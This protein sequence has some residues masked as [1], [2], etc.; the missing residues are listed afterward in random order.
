M[1]TGDA[2]DLEARDLQFGFQLTPTDD[3]KSRIE[4]VQAGEQAGLDLVGV[5]DHPYK[6]DLLDT[7][8]LIANLAGQTD[9]I[10]FFPDVANLP[11]RPPA[12]LAKAAATIDRMSSGRFDLGLGAGGY[13]SAIT[14]MGVDK[15][16]GSAAV[17]ALGEA[18]HI[19]RAL[20]EPSDR[21]I[22]IDGEHYR[23]DG[24]RP[25]PQPTR[26]IS[27]WLGSQSPRMLR[28]TGAV[29]DGWAAPIVPYLPYERWSEA[30][31]IIDQAAHDAGREPDDVVRIAQ[32]VGTITDE[33]SGPHTLEGDDP[34]HGNVEE[35]SQLIVRLATE[36][37]FSTF[38]FWPRTDSLEQIDRFANQVVPQTRSRLAQ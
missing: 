1:T 3:P 27:I 18:I 13:W 33:P 5:Q 35:W 4:L 20:W 28:L 36:Q 14:R 22:E 2:N 12:M 31:R 26:P 37:P 16:D 15:L 25:G 29:A 17:D 34:V 38:V 32:L 6:P 21:P 24:V 11:L 7:F 19:I 23:L 9:R 10:R 8:T 30:N